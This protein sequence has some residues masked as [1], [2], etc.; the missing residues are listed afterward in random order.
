MYLGERDDDGEAV[1]EADHDGRG[2]EHEQVGAAAEGE[3]DAREPA[4]QHRVRQ[5]HLSM[6]AHLREVQGNTSNAKLIGG[7][8]PYTPN[9]A[10]WEGNPV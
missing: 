4:Q 2:D 7:R 8:D 9:K 1:D 5:I 10:W 6:V 3:Q